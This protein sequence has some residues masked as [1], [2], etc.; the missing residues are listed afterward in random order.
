MPLL[1]DSDPRP[2]H[3]V[4]I[5]GAGMSAL[6][7]LFVRRGAAVTGCDASA[8]SADDLRRLGVEVVQGHD[9]AH[10]AG[11]RALVVTSA[12][13]KDH[14]ELAAA[15]AAGLPV[16][17]RAEALAEAIAGGACIGIAGTH[18]KT[19][20]TVLTTEA[21]AAAGL[22][23]TGV[24][25][26]RVGAWG[27]NLRFD[28]TERFVVEADEYDRSFL[29]LTPTVAVVTNVEADHLDIYADL[30]DIRGAF[31]EF[32]GR[33]R[34]VVACADDEGANSLPYPASAE[35]VRYGV[36]D[37]TPHPDAR[38]YARDVRVEARADGDRT[39]CEVVYDDK[40]L[41][42]LAL[43]VPGLHN[44]RNA[45][46]AVGVGLLLGATLDG[47]RAG[48]EGFGGVE[49]RFQRLGEAAGVHVVDDYAHHPTEVAATLAA[50]RAAYPSR[51]VV[52]AF[53][54]HLYTRTRDFAGAFGEALSGADAVFLTE[55]YQ[56]REQPIPG[57][58]SGRVEAAA[59][60]ARARVSWRGPRDA[61]ADVLAA[62]VR[63][64]DVVLTLG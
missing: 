45:L 7:E 50:A 31:T 9:P 48:L 37:P 58:T 3:F 22:A 38:L 59:R 49:R 62:L 24:V 52:A 54:P 5:A 43:R 53:Q 51:R 29:A 41:G 27:G 16:I 4:G 61:L 15:R 28:G 20:T 44:V 8:G 35:V 46:A 42:V 60:A 56:A 11:A 14:P 13:P 23:P 25:G 64:G 6:A 19:T 34:F 21:L 63:A 30:A 57:V 2:V 12:M 18:G 36:A 39:V 40:P 55:I 47:M 17:R 1:L 33:A 32:A 26:G 10:V